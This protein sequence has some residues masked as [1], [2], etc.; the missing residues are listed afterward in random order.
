MH[1]VYL[2][3]S[4][5]LG[6]AMRSEQGDFLLLHADNQHQMDF[7][8]PIFPLQTSVFLPPSPH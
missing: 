2:Q 8:C 5:R 3:Y 1:I 4:K 7:I 6:L